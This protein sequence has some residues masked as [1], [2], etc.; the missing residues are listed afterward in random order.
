MTRSV[1]RIS[2][3]VSPLASGRLNPLDLCLIYATPRQ[4]II[5]I[6]DI[7]GQATRNSESLVSRFRV[8]LSAAMAVY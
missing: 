3:A 6:N 4:M 2:H 8:L 1:P 7:N 5:F